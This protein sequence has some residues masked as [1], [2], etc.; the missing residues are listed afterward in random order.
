M[1]N[2]CRNNNNLNKHLNISVV[3]KD[4][5]ILKTGTFNN[6]NKFST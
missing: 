1:C 4:F 3:N 5:Y 6:G 2:H